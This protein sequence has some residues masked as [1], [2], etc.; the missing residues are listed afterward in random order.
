MRLQAWC[1]R[2]PISALDTNT[3]AFLWLTVHAYTL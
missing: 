3:I 1:C 2:N